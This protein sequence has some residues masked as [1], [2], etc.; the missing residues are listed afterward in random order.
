MNSLKCVVSHPQYSL[1][2]SAPDQ[3]QLFKVVLLIQELVQSIDLLQGRAAT[4]IYLKKG[5]T[6]SNK[7][8]FSLLYFYKLNRIWLKP[9]DRT[10]VLKTTPCKKLS[11]ESI[12]KLDVY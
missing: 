6:F 4:G 8:V 10:S 5:S 7:S 11:D 2:P 1:V 9:V 12:P 3:V